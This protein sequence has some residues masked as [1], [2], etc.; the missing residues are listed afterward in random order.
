MSPFYSLWHDNASRM[1]SFHIAAMGPEDTDCLPV[2][3]PL[4]HVNWAC[5]LPHWH[6]PPLN[7]VVCS[8][9]ERSPLLS[10]L[11]SWYFFKISPYI[12]ITICSTIKGMSSMWTQS[13][14]TA[15]SQFTLLYLT[16][17]GLWLPVSTPCLLLL[18]LHRAY[19]SVHRLLVR[20]ALHISKCL[21]RKAE[22]LFGIL[23]E[24]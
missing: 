9:L 22:K 8:L 10:K 24:M 7:Y 17:T 3:Q 1:P 4:V 5:V 16:H 12:R 18:L 21:P 2:V 19:C 15:L 23:L 13:W 14:Q 6:M 20:M 11:W